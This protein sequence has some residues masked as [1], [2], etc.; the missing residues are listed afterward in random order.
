LSRR[1]PKADP[2]CEAQ[3]RQRRAKSGYHLASR[4]GLLGNQFVA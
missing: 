4:S 1:T 3:N 2:R